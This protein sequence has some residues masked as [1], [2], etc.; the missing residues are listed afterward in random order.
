M[1]TAHPIR[2]FTRPRELRRERAALRQDVGYAPHGIVRDVI[3]LPSERAVRIAALTALACHEEGLPLVTLLGNPQA[4][5]GLDMA[6]Q[7]RGRRDAVLI[8]ILASVLSRAINGSAAFFATLG[9]S[10]IIVLLH[11]LFALIA[12]HWHW[13]GIL[14]KG[15][16][17]MIVNDGELI[18]PTMSRNH[19]SKHDLEEDLRLAVKEENLENIRAA[20]V[21]RSGDISFI[22]K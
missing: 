9:G 2:K 19:I 7:G 12:Y 8:V 14:I 6:A 22:P 4:R 3:P 17:E 20:R 5:H 13:F 16:P 18:L 15:R 10:F 21:E 11:R 1:G